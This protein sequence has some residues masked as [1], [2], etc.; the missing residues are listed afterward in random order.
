MAAQCRNTPHNPPHSPQ[1]HTAPPHSDNPPSHLQNVPA[2]LELQFQKKPAD[3]RVGQD[4]GK[5]R[6]AAGLWLG[7]AWLTLASL[8]QSWLGSCVW[9]LEGRPQEVPGSSLRGAKAAAW[10]HGGI[11]PYHWGEERRAGGKHGARAPL[12]AS[13]GP[14]RGVVRAPS[15]GTGRAAAQRSSEASI[16]SS[17]ARHSANP[18]WCLRSLRIHLSGLHRACHKATDSKHTF[19]RV[20]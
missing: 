9:H 11:F 3:G 10:A 7:M 8:N 16:H 20:V 5:W 6:S 19:Q 17:F 13:H 12:G 4:L 2:A 15:A 14:E 18:H 1:P